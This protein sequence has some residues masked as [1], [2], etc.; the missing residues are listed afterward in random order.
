MKITSYAQGTPC[1]VELA[2]T[3]QA[4]AKA[5]YADLF[6]WDYEDSPIDETGE[7]L[8]LD[9]HDGWR[10]RGWDVRAAGGSA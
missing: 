6:G 8:L 10:L 1:W 3:D 5:F 9:G 4:A 2:T 7:R